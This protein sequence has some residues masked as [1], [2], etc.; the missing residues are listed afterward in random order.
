MLHHVLKPFSHI[1]GVWSQFP[2]YFYFEFQK[3]LKIAVEDSCSLLGAFSGTSLLQRVREGGTEQR[4][5]IRVGRV[6][7]EGD[8]SPA[9]LPRTRGAASSCRFRLRDL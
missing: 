4:V 7:D 5:G 8:G 6:K 9:I 2:D 1:F 3:L